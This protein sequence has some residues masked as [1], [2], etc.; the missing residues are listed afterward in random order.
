MPATTTTNPA[1]SM[2][3]EGR[4]DDKAFRVALLRSPHADH[5]NKSDAVRRRGLAA[6]AL[7]T[8]I[9]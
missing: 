2:R 5:P 3:F 1:Y 6:L 7:R 8:Y 4:D 9:N